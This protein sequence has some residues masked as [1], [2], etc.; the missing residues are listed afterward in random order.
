MD[1]IEQALAQTRERREALQR[2]LEE[3]RASL[4][5]A[6][7]KVASLTVELGQ[8]E[9]EDDELRAEAAEMEANEEVVFSKESLRQR[10]NRQLQKAALTTCNAA[11]F[12][13]GALSLSDAAGDLSSPYF[14]LFGGAPLV[15]VTGVIADAMERNR[16]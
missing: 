3:R 8:L 13:F 7:S 9:K 12:V 4:L 6:E 1:E 11:L 2:Q 5:L 15:W 10:A 14:L 16:E